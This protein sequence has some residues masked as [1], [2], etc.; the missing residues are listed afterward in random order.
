[1]NT[2]ESAI[3]LSIDSKD[4]D[5]LEICD[6]GVR[7]ITINEGNV[8]NMK[9]TGCNGYDLSISEGIEAVFVRNCYFDSLSFSNGLE[10]FNLSE[11]TI[12]QINVPEGVKSIDLRECNI[13]SDFRYPE[14]VEEITIYNVPGLE[15]RT[16]SK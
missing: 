13:N 12:G 8:K 16:Y 1:M 6:Q 5:T 15:N 9:L 14:S 11:G 2:E 10:K 7:S 4:I 3:N